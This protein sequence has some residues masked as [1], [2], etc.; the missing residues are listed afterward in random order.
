MDTS[1]FFESH[2]ANAQVNSVL[3]MDTAGNILDISQAFTRNFGYTREDLL[4]KNFSVLF[5]EQDRKDN[6]PQEELEDVMSS[7]QANDD[8]YVVGKGG[9]WSWSA[10][11]SILVS[12]G[13]QKYVVKS[14]LNLQSRKY[15]KFL[16]MDS[17]ELMEHVFDSS[18][19]IP[20]MILDGT[21]KIQKVNHAFLGLF[22]LSDAP[23]NGSS[24]ST[25]QHPFWKRKDVIQ[26]VRSI[27]VTQLPL[28][29]T[30]FVLE[31]KSGEKKLLRFNSRSIDRG[32][33]LGRKIYIIVDEVIAA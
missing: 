23:E 14:I 29:N 16:M 9:L 13:D 3:V 33:G 6:K 25:L 4:G 21:M 1:T 31:M 27:I 12:S 20:M 24:I 11:E 22:E 10:G 18:P 8:N 19:H 5:T 2:F 30:E 15:L 28:K 26:E 17:D 32:H 7:G